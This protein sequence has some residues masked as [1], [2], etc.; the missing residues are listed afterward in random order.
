MG[1]PN[2]TPFNFSQQA[3]IP[4]PPEEEEAERLQLEYARALQAKAA[5]GRRQQEADAAAAAAAAA[6]AGNANGAGNEV[7]EI[8]EWLVDFANL[9]REITGVDSDRHVE[10]HNL[11]WDK[12]QRAMDAAL[13]SD[14]AL[15]LFARGAERF[16][17][18][19]CTGLLN[20]G[21]VHVC[22]AH[23]FLDEA[24]TNGAPLAGVADRVSAEFAEAERRYKEA[25]AYKPDFYDGA[26]ALGQ[27]EFE[28]AKLAA[29]L[30]V[31]PVRSAQTDDAEAA[32]DTARQLSEALQAAL[33]SV[34]AAS[35]AVAQGH[36]DK[37][38][39]YFKQ[40]LEF[41]DKE[42]KRS[43]EEA[44][45]DAAAGAADGKD[46]GA[47]ASATAEGSLRSSALI[48]H[49]NILYEWSQIV[50]AVSVAAGWRPLLDS[51]V[52]MFRSAGC[53][54]ADIRNALRN[55]SKKDEIDL[56]PEPEPPAKPAPAAAAT[57]KATPAAA[58]A[59]AADKKAAE[60]APTAKGLPSLAVKSKK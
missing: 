17:E 10:L 36:I 54:E 37:S 1:Y 13:M 22:I 11:G 19:T 38:D 26:C 29:G 45:E 41:A 43:E 18:V 57:A 25:M 48:M 59:P 60:P 23:K 53:A 50:G 15:P 8:D 30:L 21:N 56:G 47:A 40:A 51:A 39:A 4:R 52:A 44:K 5:A 6:T 33:A 28:R 9:F 27:L 3:D 46:G 31:K 24:A 7:Y 32:A 14:K 16:K 42:K 20:W 49:G 12:T 55:H 58:A 34:T 35:V 2:A